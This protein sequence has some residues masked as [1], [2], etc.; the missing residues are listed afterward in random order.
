MSRPSCPFRSLANERIHRDYQEIRARRPHA[1]PDQIIDYIQRKRCPYELT[2][3]RAREAWRVAIK[4]CR[5]LMSRSNGV[6]A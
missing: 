4:E 3:P 6:A 2:S 5:E 1:K